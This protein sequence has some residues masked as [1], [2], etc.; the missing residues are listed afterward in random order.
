MSEPVDGVDPMQIGSLQVPLPILCA[1][2]AGGPS[3]PALVAAVGEAGGLGWLPAGYLTPEALEDLVTDVEER[4]ARP[5]GVNL[6]LSGTE[7]GDDTDG[8]VQAYVEELA[9]EAARYGVAPGE[10][11]FTDERVAEKLDVLARHRPAIISFTFGDPGAAVVS[12]VHNELGVPVAVTVTSATEAVTAVASGAD[13]VVVQGIEAGGHRGLW[14]DD[15]S[16]PEGGPRTSTADLVRAV[17]GSVGVPVIAA[18][19]ITDGATIGS[20]VELGAVGAQLGTAF[21]CCDE[22]GTA[23]PYR[24][25]LLEGPYVDTVVTRAFS[26]RSARSLRNG[27]TER[28]SGA[29]ARYPH[30]HHV[31]KPIRS[32]ATAAGEADD[33]NLW[34]GTSWRS[35][36]AGPAADLMARLTAELTAGS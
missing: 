25:A 9:G 10:P 32:A 34:A 23:A 13:A 6:F 3:T 15:P 2:M 11:R 1:P 20:L 21:L 33:I 26:G 4:S 8:A 36:T 7:S 30:V 16:E 5:Y 14:F 18:G 28:H 19:G 24:R 17:V 35:V 12:R 27:F 22:A 31:T 29:P